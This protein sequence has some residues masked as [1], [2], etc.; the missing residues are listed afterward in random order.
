MQ[1]ELQAGFVTPVQIFYYEQYG[2]LLCLLRQEVHQH[3]NKTTLLTLRV[4]RGK[5]CNRGKFWQEQ[6]EIRQEVR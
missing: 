5:L 1:Q 2:V 6:G 4:K 3:R